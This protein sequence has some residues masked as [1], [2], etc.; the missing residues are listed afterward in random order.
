M[1]DKLR[2]LDLFE[3]RRYQRIVLTIAIISFLVLELLIYLAAASRAGDKSRVVISDANGVVVYETPGTALTSYEKMVFENT[4]G[5]LSNYHVG[6]QTDSQEFPFRSWMAAAVGIPV[7]LVLLMAFVVR[8]YLSLLYGE[9]HKRAEEAAI[10][11]AGNRFTSFFNLFNHV[12]IFHIGFLLVVG[13]LLLWLVPNFISDF[14]Q[15]SVATILRFKWFFLG[16]ALFFAF[17]VTWVI[18]LRYNLSKKMLENQ[19]DLEKFRVEKQLL[20]Q[21]EPQ[22]LLTDSSE[23]GD[24]EGAEPVGSESL[25]EE[26][27]DYLHNEEPEFLDKS[28]A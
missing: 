6:I 10:L 16:V 7:G 2:L 26:P 15:V 23:D 3:D 17:L 14:T 1:S 18:Y 8:A 24:R 21:K 22:R 19:L 4:F 5:P 9:E 11:S 20:S 28:G 12:S 27:Q 13:V 25:A